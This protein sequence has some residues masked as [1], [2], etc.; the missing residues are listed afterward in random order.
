MKIN[1][2]SV[3]VK[4]VLDR[5]RKKK[6]SMLHKTNHTAN[7]P[8]YGKI[9]SSISVKFG[10]YF[11][12]STYCFQYNRSQV[13]LFPSAKNISARFNSLQQEKSK[14]ASSNKI[15]KVSEE[16]KLTM[17]FNVKQLAPKLQVD[18]LAEK[19]YHS[20]G[21]SSSY[22]LFLCKNISIHVKQHEKKS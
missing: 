15:S 6:Q 10:L 16:I 14:L 18:I 8:K 9:I 3:V 21:P 1:R 2:H 12:N 7:M 17:K 5:Y 13:I 11:P 22:W 20:Y 19:G 4:S